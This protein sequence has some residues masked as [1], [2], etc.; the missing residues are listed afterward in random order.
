[1]NWFY[2]PYRP[3][4]GV[5][6][7][8]TVQKI[9]TVCYMQANDADSLWAMNNSKLN[10]LDMLSQIE[11]ASGN[12]YVAGL[13]LGLIPL[14]IAEKESV[15]KVTVSE[16]NK[17]VI[18]FFNG[19]GFDTSKIE[20]IN[21]PW[22][23]HKGVEPYDWVMLDHY[24]AL[25]VEKIKLDFEKFKSNNN[26]TLKLDFYRW[27]ENHPLEHLTA[28]QIKRYKFDAFEEEFDC[29]F[30][31]DALKNIDKKRSL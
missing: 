13:G 29:S 5:F 27:I 3:V 31:V 19:Q 20:I 14:L 16:I 23:T 18:H 6:N 4:R 24:D 30:L 1:M 21:E 17:E 22:E 11:T 9:A 28:E 12:V 8:I 26:G 25:D 2:L 15:S 7:T 10:V